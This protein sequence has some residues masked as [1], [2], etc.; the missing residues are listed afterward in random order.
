MSRLSR[1]GRGRGRACAD[2]L[3]LPAPRPAL[4]A[5]LELLSAVSPVQVSP[6]Y[7]L[8][9]QPES[10]ASDS[11]FPLQESELESLLSLLHESVSESLESLLSPLHESVSESLES[12][13]SPLHESVSE[14]LELELPLH[15]SLLDSRLRVSLLHESFELDTTTVVLLPPLYGPV[16]LPFT[17]SFGVFTTTGA[18]LPGG[19]VVGSLVPAGPVGSESSGTQSFASKS[20]ATSKGPRG[21]LGAA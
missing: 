18:L 2:V 9:P 5:R 13:L 6:S 20:V 16:V 11:L 7:P 1:N 14:S 3:L 17:G 4:L 10:S 8:L 19:F 12:L 21:A 15:E